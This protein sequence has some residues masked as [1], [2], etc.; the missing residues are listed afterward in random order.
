MFSAYSF[1]HAL[2]SIKDLKMWTGC[3]VTKKKAL[4]QRKT[5][6]SLFPLSSG[7]NLKAVCNH[8]MWWCSVSA[9]ENRKFP[10]L[11]NRN[12][13]CFTACCLV[14]TRGAP[15]LCEV[16]P[17]HHFKCLPSHGN[18]FDWQLPAKQKNKKNSWFNITNICCLSAK[19]FSQADTFLALHEMKHW[20]SYFAFSAI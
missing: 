1:M 6:L 15:W 17:A 4:W 11:E 13:L 18:V 8:E 2:W 3:S 10:S 5:G 9:A 20:C 12:C 14:C 16:S 19:L 7:T